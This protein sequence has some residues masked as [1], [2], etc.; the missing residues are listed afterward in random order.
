MVGRKTHEQQRRIIEGR[1]DT[2]NA[3][4]DFDA[5]AD[6]K[7]SEA[8][9]R[10]QRKGRS[11]DTDHADAREENERSILRGENQESRHHKDSGG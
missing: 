3:G 1:E 10:A 6:L 11:L 2:S 4:K 8:L 7:R 5:E 9:R